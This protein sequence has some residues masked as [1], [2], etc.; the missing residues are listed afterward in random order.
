MHS[1][2]SGEAGQR[3]REAIAHTALQRECGRAPEIASGQHRGQSRSNRLPR[4]TT[5]P[6]KQAKALM[7]Q[8]ARDFLH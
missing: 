2:T 5:G 7:G 1:D 3:N 8:S 6:V 4:Q